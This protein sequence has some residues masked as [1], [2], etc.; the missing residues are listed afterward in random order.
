MSEQAKPIGSVSWT[1]LTVPDAVS[2]RKF[3]ESVVG[4]TST[5]LDMGGYDDFCMNIPGDGTTVTGICH[6][7][8]ENANWPAGQWLIYITVADLDASL[9][10][11]SKL[12]GKVIAGPRDMGGQGRAAVI[13]DPAGAV[14]GLFQPPQSQ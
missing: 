4:W 9:Q 1:D 11:C 12:G 7:R 3:Y 6:A 2:V 14:A 8:G 13:R 5:P 10:Q